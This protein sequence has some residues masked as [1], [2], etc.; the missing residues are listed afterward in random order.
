MDISSPQVPAEPDDDFD[1]YNDGF[2][3]GWHASEGL[4]GTGGNLGVRALNRGLGT[5]VFVPWDEIETTELNSN[6]EE[7]DY[8]VPG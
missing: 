3:S 7:M 5:F 1:A 4:L 8:Y 6:G 2:G